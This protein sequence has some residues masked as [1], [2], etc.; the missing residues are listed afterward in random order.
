MD[1]PTVVRLRET[2]RVS[3]G[4][5]SQYQLIIGDDAGS[6]PL[7]TGIQTAQPGYQ[8]PLHCHPYV[9]ILHILEGTAEAW[10]EGGEDEPIVL[11]QGD[12]LAIPADTMHSFRVRGDRVLRLLGT[13]ASPKR[14]VS[15]K[16]GAPSDARGYR[17]Y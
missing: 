6:T 16:D 3:F 2:E 5:L 4:P 13:H 15:Y 7:R 14:L 9:E 8:A 12:T 10:M 1:K 11:E 17:V